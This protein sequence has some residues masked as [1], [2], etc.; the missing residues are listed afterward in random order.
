[1]AG[2]QVKNLTE[3]FAVEQ[4]HSA[5]LLAQVR[6][7]KKECPTSRLLQPTGR[8]GSDGGIELAMTV[9]VYRPAC[10]AKAK[11]LG[12]SIPENFRD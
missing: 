4:A 10:D 12:L 3:A 5:G 6:V 1:M 2:H 8:V 11:E 7:L 9:E